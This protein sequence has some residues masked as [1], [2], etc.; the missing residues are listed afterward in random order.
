MEA[1]STDSIVTR[2]K[3]TSTRKILLIAVLVSILTGF[4]IG[5]LI[6]RF[7]TCPD[8]KPEERKGVFL[9][10]VDEGL[11]R[12]ADPEIADLLINSVRS[13]NIR[14]YLK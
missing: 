5:I 6:G 4:V 1:H 8:E 12:D 11:I 3:T 9:D 2:S 10:G 13:E 7:A 14:K